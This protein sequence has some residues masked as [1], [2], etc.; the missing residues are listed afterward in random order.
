VERFDVDRAASFIWRHGRL[1]ERRRFAHGF[2]SRDAGAVAAAVRA[3]RND[4]GGFGN[5]LEPD[6]P[7]PYSQPEATR[8]GLRLLAGVGRLD[9]H[10]AEPAA[11][12]AA[13]VLTSEGAVPLCLPG[14]IGYPASRVVKARRSPRR[15]RHSNGGIVAVLREADVDAPWLLR[16]EQPRGRRLPL[17]S[18]SRTCA[19]RLMGP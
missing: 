8:I 4:D 6:C 17:P 13:S 18:G 16:A 5:A 15:G 11:A 19:R 10:V 9:E 14:V 7:T 1:L 2:V 3:Y 12:R